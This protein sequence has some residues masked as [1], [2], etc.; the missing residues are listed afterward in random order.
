MAAA[1][2]RSHRR[3]WCR[4]WEEQAAA[5]VGVEARRWWRWLLEQKKAAPV[6]ARARE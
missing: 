1:D 6:G 4:Q 2:S 3:L 5:P